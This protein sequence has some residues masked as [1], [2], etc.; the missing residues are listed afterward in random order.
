M[1]NS[2]G[3]GAGAPLRLSC[4]ATCAG[5]RK[6]QGG[7]KANYLGGVA[8]GAFPLMRAWEAGGATEGIGCPRR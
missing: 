2:W 4:R 6:T 3:V 7:S 8:V 5:G 1:G